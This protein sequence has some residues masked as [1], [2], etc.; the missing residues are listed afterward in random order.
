MIIIIKPDYA[1]ARADKAKK[2]AEEIQFLSL[3][4][5]SRKTPT[6]IVHDA[7]MYVSTA[8]K[9]T[10]KSIKY[11][12]RSASSAAEHLHVDRCLVNQSLSQLLCI[13]HFT[14]AMNAPPRLGRNIASK[15]IHS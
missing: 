9:E 14:R 7:E 13:K 4:V 11:C 1:V 3:Y 8:K 10:K 5:C 6:Q 2:D 12:C 15:F